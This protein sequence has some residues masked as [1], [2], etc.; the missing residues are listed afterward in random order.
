MVNVG[1]KEGS[2]FVSESIASQQPTKQPSIRARQL[3][4]GAKQEMC[5]A[6]GWSVLEKQEFH[7]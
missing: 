2:S 4:S 6:G 5:S 1:I 3:R 7:L